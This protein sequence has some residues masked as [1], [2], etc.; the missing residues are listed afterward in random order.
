M[1]NRMDERQQ[2]ARRPDVSTSS[3]TGD[4]LPANQP[5]ADGRGPGRQLSTKSVSLAT[6]LSLMPGLGQ[7][8][9][10]YYMRGFIH[11]A[12]VACTFTAL[13]VGPPPGVE[14]LFGFSLS[15]FWLYNMI[16]AYRR[17]KLYNLTVNGMTDIP[18]PEDVNI[19]FQGSIAGGVALIIIGGLFFARTVLGIPIGWIADWWPVAV[20]GMGIYLVV[21]AVKSRQ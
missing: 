7:I 13:S 19:P 5:L 8:Y 1:E 11:M 6:I 17:A 16:D 4:A 18:L 20:I 15:F 10:G 9:V 2:E 14:P 21:K 3:E 12:V